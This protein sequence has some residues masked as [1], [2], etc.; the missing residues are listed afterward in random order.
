MSTIWF[1]DLS[2]TDGPKYLAL[3]EAIRKAIVSTQLKAGEKLPPVR[4]L[5]WQLK[6]TPGT[7]ARAY[8][9]LTDEGLLTA[10]VGR[11]TFVAE[12]KQG[13]VFTSSTIPMQKPDVIELL[14]PLLPDVGQEALIRSCYMRMAQ[15]PNGN[16]IDYPSQ[17]TESNARVAIYNWLSD[18]DL[19][20]YVADDIMLAHGAQNAIML[21]LQTVLKDPDPVIFTEDLTY[22]GFRHAARLLRAQIV[23]LK[24]DED[25]ILP[26]SYEDAC[27]KYGPQVLCTSP[28]V[29]NPTTGFTGLARRREIVDI[30]RQ[31]GGII[32]EDDSYNL[33]GS[34]LPA[35]RALLPEQCY[36]VSSLSKS[37]TPSLRVGFV[38]APDGK[39]QIIKRAAQYNHFGL[40]I[41]ITDLTEMVLGSPELSGIREN[42]ITKVNEYVQMAV[43]ILGGYDLKW[44]E[45][46]PFLWL[47]LP[48]GWRASNFCMATEKIGVRLRSA[49]D[50]A[51]IDGR[52]PHS[53]RLTVNGRIALED[54][55][56]ALLKIEHL[57]SNPPDCIEV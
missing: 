6:V 5:G 26:Q 43:N 51:L 38:V 1:P 13:Y 36:Y 40:A 35:Y 55:E 24:F 18:V 31:Y 54:F 8:S 22:A 56:A 34:G 14:S 44:R 12:P 53:V 16:L 28:E 4:E 9:K 46:V 30:A 50:F 33:Q 45:G 52:A 17:Q 32:L 37:L 2:N 11:G 57:L 48:R 47:K 19:G 42:I 41:T 3:T 39:S 15:V 25:G 27:R 7:V 29:N 49:D 21:I 23:G 10:A 20:R